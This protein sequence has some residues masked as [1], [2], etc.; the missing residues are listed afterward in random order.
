MITVAYLYLAM[1][2]SFKVHPEWELNLQIVPEQIHAAFGVDALQTTH[3]LNHDVN[4]PSEV[5]GIFNTIS[6]G[7]GASFIRMVQHAIGFE[8]FQAALRQYI[9]DK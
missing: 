3:P 1:K 2:L 8:E 5:S 9:K 7:K 6:Y 4:S